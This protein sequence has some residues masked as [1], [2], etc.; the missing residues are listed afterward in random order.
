MNDVL[1]IDAHCVLCNR[2]ARFIE[3]RSTPLKPIQI[4]GQTSEV[5]VDLIETFPPAIQSID[6]LY[7]LRNDV[8][9]VRSS[10]AIRV[11][12]YLKWPYR[13]LFPLA[14]LIPLPIRDLGYRMVSKLRHRL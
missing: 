2:L 3:K 7:L 5:G 10:A 13:W 8:V 1:L 14:W 9:Y 4:L 11:L 6:S 12:L